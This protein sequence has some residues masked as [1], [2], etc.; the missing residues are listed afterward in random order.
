MRG[1]VGVVTS[2]A[3]T[4]GLTSASTDLDCGNTESC[5]VSGQ[6]GH[7]VCGTIGINLWRNNHC[8]DCKLC[9]LDWQDCHPACGQ[10]DA[11]LDASTRAAYQTILQ[12]AV[13]GDVSTI[14]AIAARGS[15]FVAALQP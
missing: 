2:L 1:M 8:F 9:L 3:L 4:A 13:A 5:E 7:L 15:D 10:T 11:E 12:A 6:Q 14:L